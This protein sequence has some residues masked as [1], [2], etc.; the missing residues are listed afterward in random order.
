[1]SQTELARR[2][3]VMVQQLNAWEMNADGERSLT[4]KNLAKI[5]DALGKTTDSFFV[6][7]CHERQESDI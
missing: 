7:E 6:E 2:I 4:A 1:M 3:G 5:A